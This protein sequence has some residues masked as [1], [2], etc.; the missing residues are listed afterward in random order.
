[1]KLLTGELPPQRGTVVRPDQARRA[2]P[3]SVRLRPVPRHRHGDHGQPAAVERARRSASCS[4]RKTDLTDAEGMRLGELEGHRRRRR[5]LRRPRATRRSCCRASTSPTRCTSGTMSE[6]QGGQKV[7]VLLAQ[8]LF[9]HPRSA[10][11]RRADQPPRP[12]LDSLAARVPGPLRRHADRHLARPPFPQRR[13]HPHR[14]HRLPDD[15]HLHRRLR[16]H[17]G[18]QDADPLARRGATTR[19]ARRRSR[20]CRTSSRAS[21]PARAP[22]R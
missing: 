11:A 5:R 4:T 20:S 12:R 10:A 16:R 8:A 17:G 1:M 19:S 18:G 6:M 3:G 7:R 13:L 2:A 22:A 9:G 21:P 14:R 15:H